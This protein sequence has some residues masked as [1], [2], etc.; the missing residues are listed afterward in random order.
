MT[1]EDLRDI[2]SDFDPDQEV[3][4][5]YRRGYGD[6]CDTIER[7]WLHSEDCIT[8]DEHNNVLIDVSDVE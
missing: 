4:V 2:L 7:Y 8:F 6:D 3:Y 5:Q 1:V